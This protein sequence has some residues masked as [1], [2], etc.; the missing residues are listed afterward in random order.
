MAALILDCSTLESAINSYARV[1]GITDESL[2]RLVES[3]EVAWT[4]IDVAPQNQIAH[5]L[6]LLQNLTP[7]PYT[8]RWFHAT[9][10]LPGE[11]FQEGLLP[12]MQVLPKLWGTLGRLAVEWL[13]D[14]QW[15]DYQKSF[16]RGDRPYS[17]QF[18]NKR[19]VPGWEGPFAFLV[20]DAAIGRHGHSHKDFTLIC[21]TAE[22]ICS[23]FESQ[24]GHPLRNRYESA[25]RPCLA[26][27]V[28]PEPSDAALRAT[29]NYIFRSLRNIE[30][31]NDCNA[32]FSGRGKPVGFELIDRIEWLHPPSAP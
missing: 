31:G 19:I 22:D 15:T 32:N 2:F 28:W 3:A 26:S 8:V 20:R 7:R 13:S 9:R 1:L 11:T 10:A 23:D 12:T 24:F 30:C 21:E 6:G 4:G 17:S 25:L 29:A 5:Q 16:L 18:R 14:S 27:F